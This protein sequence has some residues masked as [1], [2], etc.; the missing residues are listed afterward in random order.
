M[1]KSMIKSMAVLCVCA[2]FASCSHDADFEPISKFEQNKSE[3]ENNFVKKYG[4][5][6]PNQSWDFTS[7]GN[8][9]QA[10]VTRA[11]VPYESKQ[12]P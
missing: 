5:I 12:K 8:A 3:Y 11:N 6:D 2:A 1:K 10:R 4:A 7:N 9:A